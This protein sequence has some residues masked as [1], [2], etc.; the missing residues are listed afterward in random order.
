MTS[1]LAAAR[2]LADE[3]LFPAALATDRCD[4]VP[5]GRL[6]ALA[7]AGLYGLFGPQDAGG[8]DAD[9]FEAGAVTEALAGGCLST[10]LVW[11]QHHHAVR[12]LSAAP[13][14][15]P[16]REWLEPL[17]RGERRAGVAFAGLRRPGTPVLTAAPAAGGWRL[18]GF[19]PWVS[20]WGGV[21]VVHVGARHGHDVVWLLV[22]AHPCA[23]LTAERIALAAVNA[24]ST[25]TLTFRGHHVGAERVTGVEPFAEWQARDATGLRFN[26]SHVLGVTGRCLRLL[27]EAG[28]VTAALAAA[29]TRVRADLD[30]ASPAAMPA[31]RARAAALGVRVASTLVAAGGGRSVTADHHAQRLAREAMFLL[32]F[33]QTPA[34]RGAQLDQSTSAEAWGALTGGDRGAGGDERR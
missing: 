2:R 14:G 23:S 30:G 33:G 6:D 5:A 11:A 15:G 17:C 22:D 32:V 9:P 1:P 8:L 21:D 24:S 3:V 25:V 12:A 26:A 13:P 31:A 4:M 10:A 7:G 28:V 18:D 27:D 19:A 20:G 16:R 34:I 29:H